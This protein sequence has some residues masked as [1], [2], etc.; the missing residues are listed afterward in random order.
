MFS[1]KLSRKMLVSLTIA[2]FM[3]VAT[4]AIAFCTSKS[5]SGTLGGYACHGVASIFI[6]D[7]DTGVST[8]S[9]GTIANVYAEARLYYK[10]PTGETYND[11][12]GTRRLNSTSVTANKTVTF[13]FTLL[14]NIG[15]FSVTYNGGTWSKS[16]TTP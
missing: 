11:L 9:F 16:A 4:G 6:D 1:M 14:N 2:I 15:S 12:Y 8:T 3:L 5:V 7:A 10:V 13:G